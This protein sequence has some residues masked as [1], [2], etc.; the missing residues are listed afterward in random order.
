MMRF[1]SRIMASESA[2]ISGVCSNSHLS[3]VLLMM[4]NEKT[5]IAATGTIDNTK[6]PPTSLVLILEPSR[7]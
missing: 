2:T 7:P 3:N 1:H 4:V 5:T 6:A